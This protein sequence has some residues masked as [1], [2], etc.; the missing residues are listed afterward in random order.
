M[1]LKAPLKKPAPAAESSTDSGTPRDHN[2]S[3]GTNTYTGLRRWPFSLW[4]VALAVTMTEEMIANLTGRF[5]AERI[6]PSVPITIGIVTLTGLFLSFRSFASLILGPVAGLI[7]DRFGRKRLMTLL[8]VLQCV[9][10]AGIVFMNLWQLLVACLLLQFACG[11]SARLTIFTMAGDTAPKSGRA[12][13]MSRFSTFIDIGTAA[14]PAIAF[15]L[16]A[17]H[18]F[19]PVALLSWLLLTGLLLLLWFCFPGTGRQQLE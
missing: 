9:C 11:I 2:S 15:A 18:G 1:V 16:Y 7:S 6:E 17:N 5:V 19:L 3:I 10:V 4:G 14:G 12:L 13:H 8:A